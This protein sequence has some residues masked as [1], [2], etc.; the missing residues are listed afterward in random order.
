MF[1]VDEY[2]GAVN[3]ERYGYALFF[4]FSGGLEFWRGFWLRGGE[5]WG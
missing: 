2:P 4:L 5:R 3:F 1:G